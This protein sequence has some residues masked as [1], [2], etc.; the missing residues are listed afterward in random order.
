MFLRVLAL[1]QTRRLLSSEPAA[2]NHRPL[3]QAARVERVL[4]EALSTGQSQHWRGP[5]VHVHGVEMTPNLQVVK[6][7]CEP[8][9]DLSRVAGGEERLERL[10]RM[11][12]RRRNALTHLVNCHLLQKKATR[13]DFVWVTEAPAARE[14][15]AQEASPFRQRLASAFEQLQAEADENAAREA[16]MAMQPA[17]GAGQRRSGDEEPR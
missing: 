14:A 12:E 13:L 15:E 1:R 8:F 10:K 5:R 2:Y 3:R 4:L 6:V 7:L 9:D 11:L 16:R 17:A